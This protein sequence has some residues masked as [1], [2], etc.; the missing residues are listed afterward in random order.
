MDKEKKKEVIPF[1]KAARVGNY[2][3]WRSRT[4]IT[5]APSDEQRARVREESNGTKRAVSQSYDI[6]V[7]NVSNLEGSWKVCIPQT[8]MMYGTLTMAYADEEPQRRDEFLRMVFANMMN[9]CLSPNV[10][11][12]DGFNLFI[13]MMQYP[14]MLLSEKEMVRRMTEA[15]KDEGWDKDRKK[16]HIAKWVEHRKKLYAL[17]DEKIKRCV[18]DYELELKERKAK[19]AEAQK[20]LAQDEIAEQAMEVLNEKEEKS[21]V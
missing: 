14:Y 15:L 10:Y 2:K 9:V 17:I 19:E 1:G 16:E 20:Q 12:H 18:E 6:E 3:L 4:K 5:V 11:L 21:E 8:A 13:E 7:I